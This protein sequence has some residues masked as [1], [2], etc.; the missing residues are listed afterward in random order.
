VI[1]EYMEGDKFNRTEQFKAPTPPHR[2]MWF[3]KGAIKCDGVRMAFAAWDKNKCE[4]EKHF[5]TF[6]D[7]RCICDMTNRDGKNPPCPVH[8][9]AQ[10]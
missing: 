1:R 9:E 10:G 6:L 3:V 7:P 2:K 4:A 5:Q 8:A